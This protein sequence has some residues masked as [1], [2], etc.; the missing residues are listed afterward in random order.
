MKENINLQFK[1]HEGQEVV[2][3]KIIKDLK[4]LVAISDR[5]RLLKEGI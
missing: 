3:V 2:M 4:N 1:K 5:T